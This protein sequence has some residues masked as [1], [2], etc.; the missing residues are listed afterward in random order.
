ML[1][2]IGTQKK[3][4][5]CR[6]CPVDVD[7]L[8][9]SEEPQLTQILSLC[10]FEVPTAEATPCQMWQMGWQGMWPRTD[11][12]QADALVCCS[13][14]TENETRLKSEACL[15]TNGSHCE[16]SQMCQDMVKH[17]VPKV[18]LM[19]GHSIDA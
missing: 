4:L 5:V 2:A 8:L 1:K 15:P 10:P 19:L 13:C 14:P 12:T 11:G 9:D 18:A 6:H 17:V 7:T 16:M 3:S